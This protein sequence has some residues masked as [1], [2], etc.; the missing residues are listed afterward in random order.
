[1]ALNH[2]ARR[3]IVTVFIKE[4]RDTM[5]DRRTLYAAIILPIL[6]NPL[7]FIG[8]FTLMS[9]QTAKQRAL[10]F[11]VA[12]GRD[13][14]APVLTKMVS[15]FVTPRALGQPVVVPG[16]RDLK[17]EDI[18]SIV[19]ATDVPRS[20]RVAV[21]YPEWWVTEFGLPGT[22][23]GPT[24][25]RPGIE[26]ADLRAH[27]VDLL[28]EEDAVAL[29]KRDDAHWAR[30]FAKLDR[31]RDGYLDSHEI[32]R[33]L[34]IRMLKAGELDVAIIFP[35]DFEE[36]LRKGVS[37]QMPEVL[38]LGSSDSSDA[39]TSH[40]RNIL[41][42]FVE[43]WTPMELQDT[44]V[45]TGSKGIKEVARFIPYLII[46]M[47]LAAA[48]T[49]AIDL[50]AGEKERGTIETLLISPASRKE[51]IAGK[52]LCV[53]TVAVAAAALNLASLGLTVAYIG[54]SVA[55]MAAVQVQAAANQA[56]MA[57]AGVQLTPEAQQRIAAAQQR[58]TP[59]PPVQTAPNNDKAA[60][61]LPDVPA[62][63]MFPSIPIYLY[64]LVFLL[65]VPAAALFGAVSLAISSFAKSY[66][67]GQYY[68]TPVM[69]IAL[70]LS[71]ISLLPGID[72]NWQWGLV[73]I[74]NFAL[75]FRDI[76]TR[77]TAGDALPPVMW[78]YI[79][80]VVCV[81]ALYAWLALRWATS[82]FY[83]ED[84]LF[85]EAEEFNWRFWQQPGPPRLTPSSG[86]ALFAFVISLILFFFVGQSWQLAA[87]HEG[88]D[89]AKQAAFA[90]AHIMTQLLLIA[91]PC[92]IMARLNKYDLLSVFR[93]RIAPRA[94][95]ALLGVLLLM[96][97]LNLWGMQLLAWIVQLSGADP[98]GGSGVDQLLGS[99]EPQ[100][101]VLF[102]LFAVVPGFF[103]EIL[104]RGYVLS[105]MIP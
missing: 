79:A 5:R 18:V 101:A 81:T 90:R 82:I 59:T 43:P 57:P 71:M 58:E 49:P 27:S 67:E 56:P 11:N 103:E 8:L 76:M 86:A 80:E 40:I 74:S 63:S 26:L 88:T 35:P 104:F 73:P 45:K 47:V 10:G 15:N 77:V 87:M 97:A 24:P 68:I 102:L 7:L 13:D 91:L 85:R 96:P 29:E 38:H 53:T 9:S 60:M 31:N 55:S 6:I 12:I 48:F 33:A 69:M 17:A 1:M 70:P 2:L 75:L 93:F 23:G 37:K 34:A 50:M 51:I 44:D 78:A 25:T 52:F 19:D 41:R 100:W 94:A 83:R 89:A 14:S 66:K 95:L 28:G 36:N 64:P 32:W 92:V 54:N 98:S 62:E 46:L 39:A 84:I 72:F 16:G 4:L 20:T 42:S 105:G 30:T 61:N 65:M 22:V 21:L 3:N 99:G